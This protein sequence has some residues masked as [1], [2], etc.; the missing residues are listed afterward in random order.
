MVAVTETEMITIEMHNQFE[1][2]ANYALNVVQTAFYL[3][4][5][6]EVPDKYESSI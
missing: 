6:D 5:E 2:I 3:L 4:H 1:L